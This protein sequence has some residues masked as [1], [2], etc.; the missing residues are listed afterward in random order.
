M[1]QASRRPVERARRRRGALV[2]SVTAALLT[3][4]ALVSAS[5]V[6]AATPN[7]PPVP[8]ITGNPTTTEGAL[9]TLDLD[10]V[11]P[12]VGDSLYFSVSWGDGTIGSAVLSGRGPISHVFADDADGPDNATVRTIKVMTFDSTVG[13]E[14]LVPVTVTNV[15]PTIAVS[16]ASTAQRWMPYS[17]NVGAVTDPGKDTVVSRVIRWGDGATDTVAGAGTF[18]HTYAVAGTY[19]VTVDL[20]DED[21]TFV[22]AGSQAVTVVQVVPTAPA[23]LA[24]SAR[25]KSSIALSWANTTTDQTAVIV[26]RCKGVGCTSFARVATLGGSATTFTDIRLSARTT[27]TYR[28]AARNAVGTSPYS[29]IAAAQTPRS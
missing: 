21:G 28:V 22:A 20:L 16:G 29:N 3:G 13:V 23:N 15:A 1:L 18:S 11:D 6:S 10:A 4:G 14:T 12:D 2:G 5:S 26:E 9:Y 27:Y 25:S 24:A 19:G 17:L 8:V 7:T